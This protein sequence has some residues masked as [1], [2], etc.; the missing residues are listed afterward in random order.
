MKLVDP[1]PRIY[2]RGGYWRVSPMPRHFIKR[3]EI[4]AAWVEANTWVS[5][6]NA[7]GC[8]V[9]AIFS[10]SQSGKSR[11]M[12]LLHHHVIREPELGA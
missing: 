6:R 10:R 12:A 4:R 3:Y 9:M 2:F 1:K 7:L 11:V 5:R 8:E